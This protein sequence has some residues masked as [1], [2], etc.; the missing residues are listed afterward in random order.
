MLDILIHRRA[1]IRYNIYIQIYIVCLQRNGG[2]KVPQISP[3]GVDLVDKDRVVPIDHRKVVAFPVGLKNRPRRAC[4][5][6]DPWGCVGKWR[7]K[8]LKRLEF[9]RIS[10]K[11]RAFHL[12]F[13]SSQ[14]PKSL[15][16]LHVDAARVVAA[17]LPARTPLPQKL[18]QEAL[19]LEV[20]HL[21]LRLMGA[22]VCD[23]G[24]L[25]RREARLAEV[26]PVVVLRCGAAISH[27]LSMC[28]MQNLRSFIS[29]IDLL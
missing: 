7:P 19:R 18:A 28:S 25:Q 1:H 11:F 6:A 4:G 20:R 14:P 27:R 8:S 12:K 5:A 16:G 3:S 23:V 26:A 15:V 21:Q 9:H 2:L 10:W 17:R 29:F 22:A 24:D 13:I